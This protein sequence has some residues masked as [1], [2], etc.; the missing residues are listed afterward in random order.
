[1]WCHTPDDGMIFT[2]QQ[3]TTQHLI[4]FIITNLKYTMFRAQAGLTWILPSATSCDSAAPLAEKNAA[5]WPE[6]V[7]HIVYFFR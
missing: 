1:M 3:S 6:L 2:Q 4:H 7:A 5:A